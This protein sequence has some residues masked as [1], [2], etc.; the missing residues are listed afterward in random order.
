[1]QRVILNYAPESRINADLF[2]S[3]DYESGDAP[4]PADILLIQQKFLLFMEYQHMA[5][6]HMVEQH[7]LC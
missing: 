6:V 2:L 5:Q 3:Y 4:R 7:N 1:M